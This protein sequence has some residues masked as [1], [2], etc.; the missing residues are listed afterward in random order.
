MNSSVI[1]WCSFNSTFVCNVNVCNSFSKTGNWLF[2]SGFSYLSTKVNEILLIVWAELPPL[3][4]QFLPKYHYYEYFCFTKVSTF[5]EF[6]P[7]EARMFSNIESNPFW[8]NI[9][10]KQLP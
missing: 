9:L 6:I 7:I 5:T 2:L 4:L 8:L 10:I 1:V 3:F